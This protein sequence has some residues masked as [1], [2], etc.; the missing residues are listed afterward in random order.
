MKKIEN[1]YIH[2]DDNSNNKPSISIRSHICIFHHRTEWVQKLK[3][4][5]ILLKKNI[6]CNKY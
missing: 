6:F 2:F 5:N 1:S 4:Y 3:I